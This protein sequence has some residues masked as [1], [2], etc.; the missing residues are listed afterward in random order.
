[1]AAL[2]SLLSRLGKSQR[3]GK[4]G[5]LSLSHMA[6]VYHFVAFKLNDASQSAALSDD[7]FALRHACKNVVSVAGGANNSP[8]AHLSE[9][10][11][12]SLR[13]EHEADLA[14]RASRQVRP[15]V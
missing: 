3:G 5:S 7:F 13:S 6:S 15:V 8:E 2:L 9:V 11:S 14:D 1:M 4:P 12:P 10:R